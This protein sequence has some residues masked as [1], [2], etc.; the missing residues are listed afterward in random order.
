LRLANGLAQGE[1]GD[2]DF[3]PLRVGVVAR[4]ADLD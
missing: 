3:A 4:P 2:F 1:E